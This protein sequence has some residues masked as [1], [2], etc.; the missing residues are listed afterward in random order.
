MIKIFYSLLTILIL[1]VLVSC[2]KTPLE[3]GNKYT[4]TFDSGVGT[5]VGSIIKESSKAR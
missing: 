1:C 4:V 5:I 2:I 3:E